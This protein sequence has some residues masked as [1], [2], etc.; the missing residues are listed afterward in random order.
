MTA[1]PELLA[2]AGSME[3]LRAAIRFGADAVYL[4]GPLLQLRADSAAFSMQQ[5]AEAAEFTHNAGKKL[6]VTVNSF[7]KNSEIP[8]LESYARALRDMSVD[9]VIVS[10]L[11]AI[12]AIR[13]AVP[14][15]EVH[16]STQANCLNYAA[17]R[18]YYE[19][20]AK[21]VVLARETTLREI[22]EI[23]EKIPADMEIECFVHGAMCM[24]YSGRC[25]ISAYMNGRSGNRGDCS[26]PCRY[27]YVLSEAHGDGEY[28]PVEENENGTTLLSSRDLNAMPFIDE[29]IDAGV[30]SLKIEGR[31]KSVYYAATVINAYRHRLDNTASPEQCLAELNCASHRDYTTGFYFGEAR[32]ANA[33]SGGYKQDCVFIAV[34]LGEQDGG[35]LIEQRNNFSAGDRLEI[36]SP[37]SIGLDFVVGGMKNTDGETVTYAP[38]PQQR[39]VIT[40]P[41]KLERGDILRRRIK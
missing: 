35:Y 26:Q 21:R 5:L 23:R 4:G 7:A 27:R 18:H 9:A 11:G 1:K 40:C 31:M 8:Q 32:T 37:N 15:L 10:D 24:A 41:H 17:A 16:V 20:G 13:Q 33:E 39:L 3:S 28:Y 6:Y 2:P 12:C 19:L 30:C 29:L 14:E 25:L 34:V 36:L 22:R 38:H